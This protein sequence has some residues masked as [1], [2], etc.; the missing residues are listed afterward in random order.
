VHEVAD[1]AVVADGRR[2]GQRRVITEPSWIEVRAPMWIPVS[3][4]PRT[5]ACGQTLDRAPIV[6]R[7]MTTASGCTQ[8]SGWISGSRSP[9]A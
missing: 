6:T 7:P 9:R 5:T 4:S 1:G 2:L 8:A 3:T